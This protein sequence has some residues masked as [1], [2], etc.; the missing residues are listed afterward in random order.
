MDFVREHKRLSTIILIVAILLLLFGTTFA[1]YVYNVIHNH[2]LE[3]NEFYFNS[4]V[5]SM[6]GS[7]FK[8]NNWDGVNPYTLTIDVNNKK[9]TLKSTKSDI[10][11][12]IEVSCPSSVTCTLN[13]TSGVIYEAS[14]TDSYQITVTPK[15]TFHEGDEVVVETKATSTSPYVKELK[16]TYTVGIETLDFTYN[17]EDNVGDKFFTLNLTNTSTYYEVTK[18]FSGYQVGDHLTIEEY[19]ALTDDQKENCFSAEV[20]LSF[21]PKDIYLDMTNRKYLD[22]DANSETLEVVNNHNY[23]SGFSFKMD[24]SSSEKIIFYKKD[25]KEDYTYPITNENSVIDVNVNIAE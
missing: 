11:Y 13:K 19:N 12:D 8:I 16:G 21:V 17:I 5:L 20:T 10:S 14:G 25:P 9:N 24:A 1:R 23:V 18:A 4:S 2:I 15:D 3:S 7:E 6:D 22:R